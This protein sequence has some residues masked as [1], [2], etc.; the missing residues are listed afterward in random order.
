VD[1][2]ARLSDVQLRQDRPQLIPPEVL[3]PVRRQR[4]VDRGACHCR[5]PEP[6]LDH[7]P[8]VR[9]WLTAAAGLWTG[10]GAAGRCSAK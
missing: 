6:A 7:P 3:E 1:D 10:A 5:M 2:A 8:V 9:L 4:R